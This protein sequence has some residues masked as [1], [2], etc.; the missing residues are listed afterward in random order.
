MAKTP[1]DIIDEG[2]LGK[3]QIAALAMT[4]VLNALDGFDV[5]SISFAAPGIAEE[6]AVPK[7]V[8]GWVLS[9]EL[10][11]MAV[12]SILLG[13]MADRFGRRPT[14][15]G[16][17]VVMTTGMLLAPSSTDVTQLSLWRLL[18]GLGIGGML[19]A[20]NATVAEFANARYRNLVL[21]LML[22]G[23]PLG[24]FFG[25]MLASVWL[26]GGDWR[27]VFYLGAALTIACIPLTLWL[28][29][30]TPDWLNEKRPER[31]LERIN[32]VL[33]RFD[34]LQLKQLPDPPEK[35]ARAPLVE[36]LQ[37]PLLTRTILLTLAY[38][39]H[40]TAYY[41]FVKWI[42]KLVVDMGFDASAGGGVLTL[43]MLGGA[44]GGGLLGVV[45][46]KIGIR[47][48][49][50]ISLAGAFVMLN[51]FGR[52]P[53][54]IA[55]L[56]WI[57]GITAFFSNAAAVGFYALLA[58]AFPSRVRATGTGF[59]IGFGRAG[60][61]MGPALAGILFARGL[62]MDDVSTIISI[63]SLLS[64]FAILLLKMPKPAKG[65]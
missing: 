11:G 63:G 56:G 41:Y 7:D 40:V 21:P 37:P 28:V 30:E 23:Y 60:A 53:A 1:R 58:M 24:A 12:G 18:T 64:I 57:A 13:G 46:L 54:D 5:M 62:N 22:I 55:M 45:S 27:V 65:D 14:I 36:I 3:W 4:I 19:A 8:L 50:V 44:I 2:R 10:I 59:G 25:G 48:A 39:T 16:C 9:M 51:I 34:L 17:L 42:P 35:Q 43:A 15:I 31:A 29:P 32:K 52:A 6:W 33:Q 47:K 49:T 61:A 26:A 38:L 20:L